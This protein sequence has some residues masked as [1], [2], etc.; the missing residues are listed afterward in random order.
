MIINIINRL[1][2]LARNITAPG[3]ASFTTDCMFTNKIQ[4]SNKKYT[5]IYKL[6]YH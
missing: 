5:D 3:E 2:Y 4:F 6:V 1:S